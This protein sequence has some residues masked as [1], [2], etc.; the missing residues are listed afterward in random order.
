MFLSATS[1]RPRY[2]DEDAYRTGS[3]ARGDR[4]GM[5]LSLGII[6]LVASVGSLCF[7][8]FAVVGLALGLTAAIMGYKDLQ[9]IK[10]DE[11]DPRG[12]GQTRTGMICGIIG[13]ILGALFLLATCVFLVVMIAKAH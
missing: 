12:Q 3:Y 9:A 5:V 6:G 7:S 10:R 13:A 11:R 8:L 4:S 1:R 2:D